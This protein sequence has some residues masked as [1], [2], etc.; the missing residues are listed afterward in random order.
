VRAA[1]AS[2]LRAGSGASSPLGPALPA[3]LVLTGAVSVQL[4]AGIA[5]KL[6]TQV[7][8][9]AVTTLRLW[10][11]ALILAAV[12]GRGTVRAVRQLARRR[13]WSTAGSTVAFGIGLGVMNFA[14][15]QAF[16]RIPL[17]IAVTT[18]FLGPLAVAVAGARRLISAAW[19]ALAA[20]GV[21]LLARGSGGHLNVAGVAWALVAAAG[22]AAYI[23][24]SKATGQRMAGASGLVL[25][26]AVAAALV[27]GPG[28]VA[29]GR[30]M[31]RPALLGAGA[32]IG[33]L[34]S[35]IPYWL[36]LEA[37]RRV[38]AKVFGV[39]MSL[40][41]A[42]AALIGLVVLGQRLRAA[43]WAG[44]CCVVAASAGAARGGQS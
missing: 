37:L 36:E 44:I 26:M 24:L 9:A 43:E 3:A 27:T 21:L 6:F 12:A 13:E 41:P 11:A 5:D 17:G 30:A 42:V 29:G 15:Y 39:W 40:Q 32:A 19:V 2:V 14:I 7:P 22:W 35:V 8:P 20:A 25:A 4:G 34:S 18:E 38:P 16:A 28:V 1:P 10:A 33:L 31:F 23:L